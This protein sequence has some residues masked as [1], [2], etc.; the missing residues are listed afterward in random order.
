MTKVENVSEHFDHEGRLAET[1]L[2]SKQI[3]KLKV[4]SHSTNFKNILFQDPN[5]EIVGEH[6]DREKGNGVEVD[7][8]FHPFYAT[9]DQNQLLI[10]EVRVK[11]HHNLC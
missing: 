5:V 6:F 3:P 11:S 9:N 2:P 7:E 8:T 10:V 1:K 4:V